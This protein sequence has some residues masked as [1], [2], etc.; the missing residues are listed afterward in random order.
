MSLAAPSPDRPLH[1]RRNVELGLLILALI[2]GVGAYALVGLGKEE[3][4]PPGVAGFGM[5]LAGGYAGA[6]LAVRRFAPR[7]D[8]VLLPVAA[9]LTGIGFA[10]IYG[11]RPDLASAQTG[12]LLFALAL[13]VATLV[14]IRDHRTLDAYTYTI[15]LLG[16][17]LL[18][19][20]IVP[21]IGQEIRGA[22]LWVD[23]GPIRFQPAEIGKVLVV[24]FLASYLNARKELL[25]V[26]TR[27]I[28]P[29]GLPE[30][31]HLAPLVLA[32]GI[33]L[34]VLFLERD[35][36]SSVLFFGLF[37]VILWAATAR[38]AYLGLGAILFGV[39]SFLAYGAFA[40]VQDRVTVWLNALDPRFIQDE[41]FQLAQSVF[42]LG[43]GG[44][45]G[46]GLGQGHPEFIPDAH[47][48][49]VF[50]AVGEELGLLGAMV[51]LLLFTLIVTRAL[52]TAL[53]RPESD[54]FGRLLATGLA[55][56]LALQTFVIIGG[57][58][59]LIP[60]TG[61]TL[62]FV[63]YGG[64]SLVANFVLLALLIRVSAARSP[65]GGP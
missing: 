56:I 52:R 48:D 59:R 6:H 58:T 35:L 61:I 10:V 19:L 9:L 28:G 50:S 53:A 41:G 38:G 23:L 7:A 64:S 32:W 62:P 46:T 13:F 18:L 47:T 31:K 37:V 1:S 15:G 49:F 14:L 34:L 26:T 3:A 22:R 25:A 5:L 45:A 11:L 12:W 2:A 39:G 40:H 55:T 24:V 42:A 29:I 51:I 57:V 36:G 27:R 4:V 63:S 17:G 30:P 33:A 60:L 16:I 43:T 20:P 44:I 54:G 8:P 21:G 65:E